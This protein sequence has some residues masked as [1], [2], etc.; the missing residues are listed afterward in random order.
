MP[1]NA[2]RERAKAIAASYASGGLI[3]GGM[4]KKTVAKNTN[5]ADLSH[6]R[7]KGMVGNGSRLPNL[8]KG[9]VVSYK[10]SVSKKFGC[11]NLDS[12]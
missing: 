7:S 6:M 10:E 3:S 2:E 1:S 11:S 8:A 12:D 9:G 4:L 5:L